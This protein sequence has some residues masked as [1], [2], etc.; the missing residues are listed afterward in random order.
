MRSLQGAMK[1][2]PQNSHSRAGYFQFTFA[3]GCARWPDNGRFTLRTQLA[4]V[5]EHVPVVARQ[6]DEAAGSLCSVQQSRQHMQVVELPGKE[7]WSPLVSKSSTT[8]T[9]AATTLRLGEPISSRTSFERPPSAGSVNI[10]LQEK[11]RRMAS[12]GGFGQIRIG[13][14]S[15]YLSHVGIDLAAQESTS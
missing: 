5:F 1:R 11:S 8:L 2:P 3:R 10:A 15:G 9:T 7:I 13:G 4:L 6:N 14:K 12:R